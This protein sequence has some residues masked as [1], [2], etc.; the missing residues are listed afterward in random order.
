VAEYA[1]PVEAFV[2]IPY[3]P[4][5]DNVFETAIRPALKSTGVTATVV[6]EEIYTGPIFERIQDSINRA[7]FCVADVTGGNPNVMWE[8]A[9]AHALGKPVVFVAQGRAE[10]IPFDVRHNRC[11]MYDA[12][13]S[14]ALAKLKKEIEQT[15]GSLLQGQVSDVQSM[16]Q[17]ILPNSIRGFSSDLVV[18]ANPLSWRAASRSNR[19]WENRRV[20]TFSDYLGIRGLMRSFGVVL[21]MQGLP[22]LVNPDDFDDKVLKRRMHL[23]VIGSPKANRW[24]GT[25]MQDFFAERQTKWVFRPDPESA[26]IWNPRVIVQVNGKPY[27]PTGWVEMDRTH[28][29]FGIVLRGPNPYD[30]STMFTVLAGRSALG[31]EASSLAVTDPN[32]VRALIRE[33][34][35]K[36]I[37]LENHRQALLAVV[38]VECQGI[39]TEIRTAVDT[40]KVWE[41]IKCD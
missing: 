41:V 34:S 4:V 12:D 8:A 39:G 40:F 30:H 27:T 31:T 9:Y 26:Y 23:Y 33:L 13:S 24:T 35:F 38:S 15:V 5:F 25:L 10:A 28:K 16:R 2:M 20:E 1:K 7:M 21:G 18:A 36:G 19:G 29:D 22:D 32:C 37:D 11:I 3:N 14:E 6:K 17:M